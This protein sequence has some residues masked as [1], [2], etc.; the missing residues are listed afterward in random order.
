MPSSYSSP[1]FGR[2]CVV[3]ALCFLIAG[4]GEESETA[5][6]PEE[7]LA[8]AADFDVFY[9]SDDGGYVVYSPRTEDDSGPW[10]ELYLLETD[11]GS[12]HRLGE[13]Y[14]QD[15]Y[16]YGEPRDVFFQAPQDERLF[17]LVGGREDYALEM[18]SPDGKET[19]AEGIRSA[20]YKPR[21]GVILATHGDGLGY[22][23]WSSFDMTTGEETP[24]ATRADLVVEGPRGRYFLFKTNHDDGPQLILWD[25]MENEAVTVAD[26]PTFYY[27]QLG[28][29]VDDAGATHIWYERRSDDGP[30]DS[31]WTLPGQVWVYD[32]SSGEKT[33]L[34]ENLLTVGIRGSRRDRSRHLGR[35]FWMTAPE[36]SPETSDPR[37]TV[38]KS[39]DGRSE[40][41]RVLSEDFPDPGADYLLRLSDDERLAVFGVEPADQSEIDLAAY[42]FEA[43]EESRLAAGVNRNSVRMLSGLPAV[44]YEKATGNYSDPSGSTHLWHADFSES[45][46]LAHHYLGDDYWLGTSLETNT[47][48]FIARREEGEVLDINFVDFSDLSLEQFGQLPEPPMQYHPDWFT[49]DGHRVLYASEDESSSTGRLWYVD[50]RAGE[51]IELGEFEADSL[52][53]GVQYDRDLARGFV[54][55]DIPW[56]PS[57]IFAWLDGMRLQP[58][59][60]ALVS[61]VKPTDDWEH[62]F[63]IASDGADATA[64]E[65][66]RFSFEPN[67][68]TTLAEGVSEEAHR[69]VSTFELS[70]DADLLAY[71]G[72]ADR[73]SCAERCE[74]G[75]SCLSQCTRPLLALDRPR[76][77]EPTSPQLL[78]ESAYRILTVGEDWV[79]WVSAPDSERDESAADDSVR[80]LRFAKIR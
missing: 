25:A 62:L 54:T 80:Y 63:F 71:L 31:S 29:V 7:T 41:V 66:S 17:Y 57:P 74:E 18:W 34:D 64:G 14:S 33:L 42:D 21:H 60:D 50:R 49:P 76:A 37:P 30:A 65:L 9:V 59:G 12:R 53:R 4:C 5:A 11:T 55:G 61:H 46:T 77:E 43:D 38:L 2:A 70:K 79:V 35:I 1:F 69:V 75:T 8:G 52:G 67:Q 45:T 22:R 72:E 78:D 56:D 19:I 24:I 6:E 40:T 48:A 16:E 47:G 73:G 3:V 36:V 28:F 23:D 10:R 51:P 58:A 13:S 27:A 15:Y 26:A 39:W 68:T 20:E 44:R 32:L